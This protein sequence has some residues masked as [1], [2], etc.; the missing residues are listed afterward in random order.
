MTTNHANTKKTHCPKGHEYTTENTAFSKH[1][2][3]SVG[4]KCKTCQKAIKRDYICTYDRP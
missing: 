2:N 1:K 4:R 3:G